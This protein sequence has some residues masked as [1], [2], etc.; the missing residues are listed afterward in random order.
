MQ[1][2]KQPN[3]WSCSVTAFAMALDV[4]IEKLI[5]MVGHDGSEILWP[6]LSDPLRRR[7]FHLQEL[8]LCAVHLDY[9]PT[10]WEVDTLFAPNE[11]VKPHRL[12]FE[13]FLTPLITKSVR[14]VAIGPNRQGNLHA[15]TKT[16]NYWFD[17]C[18][19]VLEAPSIKIDYFC[20]LA[21]S[22]QP[23]KV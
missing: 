22:S 7:G 18:G 4:S 3:S 8:M 20:N 15:I 1:L 14:G 12:N 13:A 16:F 9:I 11:R 17:P 21:I 2:L 19:Q 23:D 10:L 5:C 6:E